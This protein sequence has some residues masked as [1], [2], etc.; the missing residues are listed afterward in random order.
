M[1]CPNNYTIKNVYDELVSGIIPT[2]NNGLNEDSEAMKPFRYVVDLLTGKLVGDNCALDQ[3]SLIQP[4]VSSDKTLKK[5]QLVKEMVDWLL[6]HYNTSITNENIQYFD[7]KPQNCYINHIDAQNPKYDA[8]TIS[9]FFINQSQPMY[10]N[11]CE[12]FAPYY[13]GFYMNASFQEA[14]QLTDITGLYSSQS[15]WRLNSKGFPMAKRGR[16]AG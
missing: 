12:M 11:T 8:N 9:P 10:P 2:S 1:I 15:Y 6:N 14:Q 13:D 7:D 16:R 5:N 4:V 3:N